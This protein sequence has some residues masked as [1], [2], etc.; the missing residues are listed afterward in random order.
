MR[1]TI[2]VVEDN[3]ETCLLVRLLLEPTYEVVEYRSGTEALEA[4]E[5]TPPHLV[6]LDISLPGLDGTEVLALIRRSEKLSRLPVIAFTAYASQPE[7]ERYLKLG[8][9]DH[10]SKP[11]TERTTFLNSIEKLLERTH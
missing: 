10:V 8:F 9:D 4:F 1:N 3:F 2:A 11:I 7:R 5:R 6:L